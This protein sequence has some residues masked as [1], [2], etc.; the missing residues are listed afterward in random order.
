M[1]FPIVSY[2]AIPYQVQDKLWFKTV[3]V[4]F[5]SLLKLSH[6]SA[7]LAQVEPLSGV[8]SLF[9]GWL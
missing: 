7:N 9:P 6:A 2:V 1:C 3:S 8:N 4:E 5:S